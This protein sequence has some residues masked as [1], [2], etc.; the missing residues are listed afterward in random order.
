M[1]WVELILARFGLSGGAEQV[2]P[3]SGHTAWLTIMTSAAMAFLAVFALALSLAADR[4]AD[5][6][7]DEL[8]Q[9]ATVRISAA[10]DQISAQVAGAMDVLNTTPGI[11]RARILEE[12]E[13][14][15]LLEPWF[16]PDLPLDSLPIPKLI[17]IV[18]SADGF[19][20]DLLNVRLKAEAPGAILDD[21]TR[22]RAPLVRSAAM[23]RGLGYLSVFLIAGTLAGM[24]T[25]AATA[26][27]AANAQVIRVLR[28]I[29]ARD[30]YIAKAFVRRFT[31]R[32]L[33]GAAIGAVIGMLVI[34]ALPEASTEGGFLTG[35]GFAGWQWLWPGLIPVI[36]ATAAFLAT[37]QA[38][39]RTLRGMA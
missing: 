8:A 39:F 28:L 22:W 23:L 30:S 26:A 11:E 24:I 3:P 33:G 7:S 38:A 12:S 19:D 15:A 14:R 10:S 37:R 4:L 9:T 34:L 31:L 27:L 35:L 25:L 13:E 32:A 16:G 20:R 21:H 5:R 17:E 6:W 18:E 1:N 29:G 2:V 36:A